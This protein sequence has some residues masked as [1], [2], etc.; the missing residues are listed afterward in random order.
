MFTAQI[1]HY[2]SSLSLNIRTILV[3]VGSPGIL[4]VAGSRLMLNLKEAGRLS[5]IDNR[6]VTE[7]STLASIHFHDVLT[8]VNDEMEDVC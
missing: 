1:L 4:G 3:A 2:S 5:V 6:L 7:Q 8:V